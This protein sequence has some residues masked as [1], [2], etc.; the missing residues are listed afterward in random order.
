MSTDPR[1]MQVPDGFRA[2]HWI[3]LDK[4]RVNVFMLEGGRW[5]LKYVWKTST[6]KV[7]APTLDQSFKLKYKSSEEG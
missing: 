4:Q 2:Y 3:S 7:D 1:M 5:S 6:G